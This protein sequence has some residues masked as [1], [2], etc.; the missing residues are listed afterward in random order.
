MPKDVFAVLDQIA[1]PA[2]VIEADSDGR[3][4]YTAFNETARKVAA[5]SL[6]DVIGHD[7]RQVY[8]GRWGQAA[9]EKHRLALQLREKFTYELT[10]PLAGAPHRVRTTLSPFVDHERE[11]FHL[12][13]TSQDISVASD[14]REMNVQAEMLNQEMEDFVRLA[15]HDLRSPIRNVRTLANLLREDFQD[16]GDG[17]LQIIDMLE[18]VA[19]KA[20]SLIADVISHA[21]ATGITEG[22]EDF[23]LAELANEVLM[24]L[25]PEE[26]HRIAVTNEKISGDK[27]AAQIVLRNLIDNA[28][29]HNSESTLSMAVSA[30]SD[31]EKT[32]EIKVCDN[33]IGFTDAGVAHLAGGSLRTDSG[34]GLAGIRRLVKARG[35]QICAEKPESGAGAV[36]RF[37]LPGHVIIETENP[38]AKTNSLV[39][40]QK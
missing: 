1:V 4:I 6:A 15:A 9:F 18:R 3:P 20:T 10:L 21:Q 16:L 39:P 13:G 33:G 27:I 30:R 14:V 32:F 12:I 28:I 5:L 26:K 8:G 19:V 31:T 40:D 23:S 37:S 25:D 7:A 11:T 22:I 36:V 2:F 35:G 29:K 38:V 24:M 34:F 17:K